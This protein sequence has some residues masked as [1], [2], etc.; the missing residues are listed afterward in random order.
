MEFDPFGTKEVTWTHLCKQ[1]SCD[2]MSHNIHIN[3]TL[4]LRY[5]SSFHITTFT[6]C[7]TVR[8]HV[9]SEDFPPSHHTNIGK[10]QNTL[11]SIKNL[12]VPS[13]VISYNHS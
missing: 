1:M 9:A 6:V 11:L 10:I 4:A 13:H 12:S 7:M 2:E 8:Y 5:N 3:I